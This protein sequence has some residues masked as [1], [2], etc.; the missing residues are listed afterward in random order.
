MPSQSE[1]ERW[2]GTLAGERAADLGKALDELVS[3]QLGSDEVRELFEGL[4]TLATAVTRVLDD[5]R[6]SPALRER[7]HEL[8]LVAYQTIHSQLEQAAAASEDL[9][10]SVEALRHLLPEHAAGS[11]RGS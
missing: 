4:T 7:E 5:L 1:A 9:Q 11:E 10:V 2:P 8:G 3:V 6:T